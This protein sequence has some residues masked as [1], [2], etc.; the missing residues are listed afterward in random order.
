MHILIAE[1]RVMLAE[2]REFQRYRPF[3]L[4]VRIA[5]SP[6]PPDESILLAGTVLN[7]SQR[8]IKVRLNSPMPDAIPVSKI[9]IQV[10]LPESGLPVKIRGTIRHMNNNGEI[11]VQ[12]H[13]EH[14][15]KELDN[16]LFECVKRLH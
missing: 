16:M 6:P 5:I 14:S 8:G 12:Y 9:V 10:T 3:N 1:I 2:K 15:D 4:N 13:D 7:M 11:G